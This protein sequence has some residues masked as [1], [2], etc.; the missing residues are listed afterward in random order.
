MDDLLEQTRLTNQLLR[1]A[2]GESIEAR[3]KSLSSSPGTRKVIATLRDSEMSM[4]TLQARTG[5]PRSSLYAAVAGLERRGV[6]ERPRR[7]YVSISSAAAPY[8][9]GLR[10]GEAD[11]G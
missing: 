3:L 10:G 7:G 2:F 8:L 9:E 6:V 1:L 5:L 11:A 4:E